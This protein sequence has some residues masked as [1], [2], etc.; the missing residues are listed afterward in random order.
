M[1]SRTIRLSPLGLVT[2]VAAAAV[3]QGLLFIPVV[4][5]L[6]PMGAAGF[7]PPMFGGQYGAFF[8]VALVGL[9]VWGF[10]AGGVV[11]WFYNAI[12]RLQ[13]PP[14]KER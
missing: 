1:D 6:H 14:E 8:P 13:G 3:L 4:S 2:A 7:M 12:V 10:V 11:A 9:A 5:G